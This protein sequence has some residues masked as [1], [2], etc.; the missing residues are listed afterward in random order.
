MWEKF[1]EN[2]LLTLISGI[3]IHTEREDHTLLTLCY[4]ALLERDG[5]IFQCLCVRDASQCKNSLVDGFWWKCAFL[6]CLLIDRHVRLLCNQLLHRR[7]FWRCYVT[8]T[9]IPL[10][11]PHACDTHMSCKMTSHR[12]QCEGSVTKEKMIRIKI[13]D[14]C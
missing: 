3:V 1:L 8:C 12:W 2:S 13:K 14:N 5:F 4:D 11:L 6:T 7:E 10:W 9:E